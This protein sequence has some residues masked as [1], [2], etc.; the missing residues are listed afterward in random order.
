M[1]LVVRENVWNWPIGLA[2]NVV[3]FVLFL[4]SR[5]FADMGLQ[6]LY[7]CLGLYGWMNWL[8]GG[9]YGTPLKISRTTR[10]E[11]VVHEFAEIAR[12]QTR[13]EDA[14]ARRANRVLVCDTNAFATTLWHRRYMGGPSAE[15]EAIA[16]A[17]RCDLYLLT[18]DEIPFVQDGLRDGEHLRRQMHRWFE[19]ALAAQPVPWLLLRGSV[20]QRRA[21]AK[22]AIAALFSDSGWMPK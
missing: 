6:V 13:R 19:E 3:F 10:T 17:G 5:L 1:W 14:A 15:V 21:V 7:F 11:W 9:A 18:G 4:Q 8:F 16:R 20:A 22:S 12:E 2:N